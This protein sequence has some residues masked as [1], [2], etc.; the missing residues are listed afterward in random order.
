MP[1]RYK[2]AYNCG[3]VPYPSDSTKFLGDDEVVEGD[4]WEQYVALGFV[5]PAD[6]E[7]VSATSSAKDTKSTSKSSGGSGKRA[8]K[9]ASKPKPDSKKQ[10]KPKSEGNSGYVKFDP[11]GP[12]S[13]VEVAKEMDDGSS[14]P[15]TVFSKAYKAA[16][17]R[18]SGSDEGGTKSSGI[19][20]SPHSMN[21]G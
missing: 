2:K 4:E 11:S 16:A 7:P 21:N 18:S 19:S 3:K 14:E 15:E 9:A 12:K 1:K 5:V 17:E 20:G 10:E 6:G 8:S 13:L